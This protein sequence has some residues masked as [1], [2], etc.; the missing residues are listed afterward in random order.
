MSTQRAPVPRQAVPPGPSGSFRKRPAAGA[1]GRGLVLLAW[2]AA[3]LTAAAQAPAGDKAADV[4][5]RAIT[6][7]LFDEARSPFDGLFRPAEPSPAPL[8]RSG[9]AVP[10]GESPALAA[11]LRDSL[12]AFTASGQLE[13][14]PRR[15]CPGCP[16]RR[17]LRAV[18]GAAMV[19]VVFNMVNRLRE[20]ND[21]FKVSFS[22]WWENLKYG[23]EWDYNSFEINQFGHP[24]QGGLYFNAGRAN[25]LS[26]WESAPL[27]AFGSATW[28][29]FGEKNPASINDFVTTTMGGIALGEMF[30]R[31][32]WMVRD[33]SVSESRLKKEL[34]AMVLDPVTGINRFLSGDASRV[35]SN[36]E[37]LKPTST[38]SDIEA[39]V[40]WNGRVNERAVNSTG[41]PF[42]GLNLGYNDLYSSPYKMPFDAFTLALRLG[43]GSPIS[44]ALVRGRL[45]GRFRARADQ[46]A[47]PT[48]FLVVQGYDF[49]KNGIFEY[50]GQSVLAGVSHLFRVSDSAQ[51]LVFGVGG[52]IVLGAIRSPLVTEAPAEGGDPEEAHLKRTYDFGPGAQVS[53]GAALRVGG[54]PLARLRYTSF[55]LRTISSVEGEAGKHYAQVLRL[56][57]LAPLWRNFRF[58]V[59]G[60]YINRATYY[61]T[62]P[63]VH[64]WLPQLR[65]YLARVSK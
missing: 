10:P 14:D 3:P 64:Q 33:S 61:P 18:G 40:Q 23:F 4:P 50:G 20:E 58:G 21:E 36:P 41:E 24:Y 57:V 47:L 45:Y 11:Y 27:A 9:A 17:P 30:H 42:L 15:E 25:G 32:G 26:F 5:A 52:P 28:E 38:A 49:Q 54:F 39:G 19:N 31:A 29:Y 46:H 7:P 2:L 63:D 35:S 48:E 59:S 12:P 1:V 44:E 16:R 8:T 53:G 62:T 22:S 37:G 34:L 55:F 6:Q 65:V 13:D 51:L 43:G 56:D 60:D